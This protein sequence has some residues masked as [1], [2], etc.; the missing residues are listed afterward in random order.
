MGSVH[1]SFHCVEVWVSG[2]IS[3]NRF[4]LIALREQVT[5]VRPEIHGLK[6][7]DTQIR[8]DFANDLNSVVES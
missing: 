8:L 5:Y 6:D 7:L 1:N 2:I 4:R 3:I